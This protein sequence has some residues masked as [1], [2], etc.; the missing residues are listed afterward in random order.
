[1]QSKTTEHT[2]GPWTLRGDYVT[3]GNDK[4]VAATSASGA[5]AHK[6]EWVAMNAT[7]MSGANAQLI[8]AAPDLLEALQEC[9]TDDGA[10]AMGR[11]DAA[12]LKMRIA[13]INAAAKIAIAK[14]L[15]Q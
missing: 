10:Y 14:A 11:N 6:D 5:F 2:P 13:A 9:I 4:M 3:D 8:A 1:M 7:F 12:A 15:G